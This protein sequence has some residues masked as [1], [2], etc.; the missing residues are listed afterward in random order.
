MKKF[1]TILLVFSVATTAQT[2]TPQDIYRQAGELST[3]L[4]RESLVSAADIAAKLD[5]AVQAQRL[6]WLVRDAKVRARDVIS[7]LPSDIESFWV[8]KT[9]FVLDAEKLTGSIAERAIVS[10][11]SDRL[12]AQNEGRFVDLLKGHTV[13]LVMAAARGI[14][15]PASSIPGPMTAHD[16]IYFYFLADAWNPEPHEDETI[17]GRPAWQL[18]G[19]E[20]KNWIALARPDLLILSNQR[21]LL[22]GVLRE[23]KNPNATGTSFYGWDVNPSANFSGYRRYSG[24]SKPKP[25]GRECEAARLP[26]PDWCAAGAT[27]QFNAD[28]HQLQIDYLSRGQLDLKNNPSDTLTREFTIDHADPSRWRLISDLGKRGAFPLDFGMIMLGFGRYE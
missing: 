21:D 5:D 22:A 25:R 15:V 8:N 9:P 26:G 3:A 10:Y 13:R 14:P 4:Q 6:T 18:A 1:F 17:E 28:T 24:A 20:D 2:V 7:W 12:T 27:L 19:R 16:A 11:S 23:M